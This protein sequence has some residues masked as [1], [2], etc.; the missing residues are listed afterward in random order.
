MTTPE[1]TALIVALTSLIGALGA[2]YKQTRET[3]A[4]VNSRMTELLATTKLAAQSS[5]ELK[6]RDFATSATGPDAPAVAQTEQPTG[7]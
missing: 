6:G 5:G 3:H 7:K 1:F 4:L 2:I